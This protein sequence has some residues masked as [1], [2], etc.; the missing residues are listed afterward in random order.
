MPGLDFISKI[1]LTVVSRTLTMEVAPD[2]MLNR[3][4]LGTVRAV[5]ERGVGVPPLREKRGVDDDQT[6]SHSVE[7]RVQKQ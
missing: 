3:D 5:C 7:C 1:V 6:H 4:A 2:V